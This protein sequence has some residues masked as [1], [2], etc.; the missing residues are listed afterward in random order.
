MKSPPFVA[1]PFDRSAGMWVRGAA[2][3]AERK[4]T[5]RR[6]GANVAG[7]AIM[8]SGRF[9]VVG[10]PWPRSGA[11]V[12]RR[13]APVRDQQRACQTLREA[14]GAA[15]ADFGRKTAETAGAAGRISIA[16]DAV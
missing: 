9:A 3:A 12:R 10:H 15:A 13:N 8:A 14:A 6:P 7:I 11:S 5:G 4:A 1:G 16:Q 2:G